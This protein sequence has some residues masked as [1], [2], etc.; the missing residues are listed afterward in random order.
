GG[1]EGW[2]R[3][4]RVVGVT[5]YTDA[6][7]AEIAD[8]QYEQHFL[9]SSQKL[10]LIVSAAGIRTSDAV[11]EIGAG[12]G[13]VARHFPVC[14][15]LTV[16]ELDQRLIARLRDAVPHATVIQGDALAL[17]EALPV[18]VLVSNLPN[19]TT[20]GLL[21]LLPALE[22]RTAIVAMSE[23]SAREPAPP[24]Y[25]A[26]FVTTIGGDDFRPPQPSTSTVVRLTRA[27]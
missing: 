4:V 1:S 16:I 23:A 12:A 13:T 20:A 14:R 9:V 10:N 18:D 19:R 26:E 3:N 21:K 7:L 2:S 5:Q 24:G 11:V 25:V 27:P 15:S 17:L 6:D 8:P 22:L